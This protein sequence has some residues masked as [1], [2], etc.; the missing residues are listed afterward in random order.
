MT[1]ATR[2]SSVYGRSLDRR[3][4]DAYAQ[5]SRMLERAKMRSH[6]GQCA[7]IPS[8]VE[9]C[10]APIYPIRR[11]SN[12]RPRSMKSAGERPS[13][14]KKEAREKRLGNQAQG[15]RFE[16]VLT[17][18]LKS[19]SL[20]LCTVQCDINFPSNFRHAASM[21]GVRYTIG[22]GIPMNLKTSMHVNNYIYEREHYQ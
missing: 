16:T 2:L 17:R 15:Y 5:L 22:V 18:P 1:T 10:I 20:I 21:S 4:F 8:T 11:G 3:L 19:T 12:S 7:G 6:Y 13:C 9:Y 14:S